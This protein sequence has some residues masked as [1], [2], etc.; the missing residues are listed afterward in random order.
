MKPLLFPAMMAAAATTIF[1][2]N[3]ALAEPKLT[4]GVPV[5]VTHPDDRPGTKDWNEGWFS[6][7]GVFS[8]VTWPIAS[9]GSR[10]NL[11][12]GFSGGVF[13]NSID[14]TSVFLG[15]AGEVETSVT[16]AL[17]LAIGTYAGGVTG[18]EY[19][20]APG[21]APYI[22]AT[23][24]ITPEWELGIR[25]LWLPAKTIAGSD[26]APSDAYIGAFTIGYQF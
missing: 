6:N 13:D 23:Y 22:G 20:V 1:L 3:A 5:Y 17:S 26:L 4:V 14:R 24:D 18:Y 9:L 21:L 11:R 15:I 7:P 19:S 2:G 25:G 16:P 12:A 8:D 10:T